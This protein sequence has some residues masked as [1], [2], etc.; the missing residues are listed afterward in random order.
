[1]FPTLG[2]RKKQ[3]NLG[4]QAGKSL[5]EKVGRKGREESR[6]PRNTE[7]RHVS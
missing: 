1:M 5:P 2:E 6:F 4:E 7:C 3:I